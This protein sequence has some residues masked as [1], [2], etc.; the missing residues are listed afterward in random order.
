MNLATHKIAGIIFRTESN[1]RIPKILERPFDQ[2]SVDP[3]QADVIHSISRI[4]LDSSEQAPPLTLQEQQHLSGLTEAIPN[5]LESPLLRAERVRAR[6]S[7]LPISPQDRDIWIDAHHV[8]IRDFS[9]K[10]LDIFYTDAFRQ[11]SSRLPALKPEYHIAANLSQ[12]FSSYLPCFSAFLLH[13]SGV[14][15]G[16]GAALFLAPDEGGKTTVLGHLN[17]EPILSDDHTLLRLEDDGAMA[18]GTPFGTMTNGFCR[19]R[20]GALFMLF[21]SSHF[22]IEPMAPSELLNF[23]WAEHRDYTFFLPRPL[24]KQ[25]F[26]IISR[27]CYQTPVYR[28]YFPKD[29]VDWSAIDRAMD[30][31]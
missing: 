9:R 13:S 2:F 14:I 29:H 15:R 23:I 25:A 12:I 28:M 19:A 24:K 1:A 8:T 17:G 4:S 11:D 21:K 30:R 7:V 31:R 26:Q 18:H 3:V 27:I 10:R 20:V 22:H 16:K 5:W 6:L